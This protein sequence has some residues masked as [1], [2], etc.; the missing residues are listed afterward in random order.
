MMNHVVLMLIDTKNRIFSLPAMFFEALPKNSQSALTEDQYSL[1][2]PMHLLTKQDQINSVL[3][4]RNKA[5]TADGKLSTMH[6]TIQEM[7]HSSSGKF[8]SFVYHADHDNNFND[9][10]ESYP[11]LLKFKSNVGESLSFASSYF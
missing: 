1:P 4:A 8:S 7:I 10:D 11:F 6:C 9:T 5:I 2:H 3:T